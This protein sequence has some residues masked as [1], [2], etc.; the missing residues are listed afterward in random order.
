MIISKQFKQPEIEYK[1][2]EYCCNKFKENMYYFYHISSDGTIEIGR[3]S[4]NS[5]NP[6]FYLT[7]KYCPH[8]GEKIEIIDR[9]KK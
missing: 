5:N 8:C 9:I 3:Y 2:L 7:I 1:V 6:P 4:N